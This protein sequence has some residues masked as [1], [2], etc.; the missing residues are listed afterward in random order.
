MDYVSP[1]GA[2]IIGT[3]DFVYVLANIVGIGDDGEPEYS[4]ESDVD[5]DSQTTRTRGGKPL[6]EDENGQL[7][8]FDQLVPADEEGEE[9]QD[10]E[11]YS[12]TQD[13]D[14]YTAA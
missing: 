5:W 8:T 6:F 1:T 2:A 7:W 10:R 14:N 4:G 3:A 12:D 13:R 11:A 9:G